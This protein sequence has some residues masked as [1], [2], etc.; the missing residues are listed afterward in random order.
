[1]LAHNCFAPVCQASATLAPLEAV[2]AE[3]LGG[4][5]GSP[6][7]IPPLH[8]AVVHRHVV[9]MGTQVL[10][11]GC[12]HEGRRALRCTFKSP[13]GVPQPADEAG[14]QAPWARH[15]QDPYS[16]QQQSRPP[17]HGPRRPSP[18]ARRPCW[19]QSRVAAACSP[20]VQ[21]WGLS[22]PPPRS[23]A[24]WGSCMQ[25]ELERHLR[26]P[27]RRGAAAAARR[28]PCGRAGLPRPPSH[29]APPHHAAHAPFPLH[30]PHHAA[31]PSSRCTPVLGL[32]ALVRPPREASATLA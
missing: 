30:P 8:C 6:R 19:L 5:L 26:R 28:H 31:P 7:T 32:C 20:A 25:V 10:C 21:Q 3:L 1:M 14:R 29:A 23:S 24:P 17:T 11:G 15:A 27:A 4:C 13:P 2:A 22:Q 16:R 9:D 18:H 12:S